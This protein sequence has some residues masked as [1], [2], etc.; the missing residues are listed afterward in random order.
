MSKNQAMSSL[1]K[2]LIESLTYHV[3]AISNHASN[4]FI[5]YSYMGA[6][7]YLFFIWDVLNGG[8]V[9]S[10]FSVRK[11]NKVMIFQDF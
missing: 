4:L 9:K 5:C 11:K 8:W 10:S 3:H 6:G 2:T 1:Q 7:I